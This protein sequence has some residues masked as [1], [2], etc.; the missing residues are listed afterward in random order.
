LSRRIAFHEA[1]T[2]ALPDHAVAND[3]NGFSAWRVRLPC[4][5]HCLLC[6]SIGPNLRLVHPDSQ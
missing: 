2:K 4:L 5:H 1:L 3:D 6:I